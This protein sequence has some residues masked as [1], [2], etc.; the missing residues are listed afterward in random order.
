MRYSLHEVYM[1]GDDNILEVIGIGS[2]VVE[3]MVRGNINKI[4]INECLHV[5]KLHANLL[6]VNK[7]VSSGLKVQFNIN[8]C[9]IRAS[10]DDTVA[11][12]PREGNLYHL[13]VV[14]E[15]G[16]DAANSVQSNGRD[17]GLQLWHRRLGHLNEKGVPAL[18]SMVTDIDLTQVSCR[19]SLV[20][21]ACIEGKQHRLSFR[22]KGAR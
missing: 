10:D 8:E 11:I 20:C 7:L 12:A 6:S 14:K 15:H 2:I 18:R 9:I 5:P 16:M 3:V 22:T 13:H 19:S 4:R 17:G 21:K 1:L